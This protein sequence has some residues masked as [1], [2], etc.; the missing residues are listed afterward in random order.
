MSNCEVVTFLLV[1]CARCGAWIVSVPDLCP[2]SYF[3]VIY[4]H[5]VCNL[6]IELN[7]WFSSCPWHRYANN[8]VFAYF[9]FALKH[10]IHVYQFVSSFI[11]I[12]QA[13]QN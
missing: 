1:S 10:D 13:S 8:D 6:P 12:N 9:M 11:F 2:H 7:T 3:N 4:M 5:H